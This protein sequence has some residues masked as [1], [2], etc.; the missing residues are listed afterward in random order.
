MDEKDECGGGSDRASSQFLF[1][2]HAIHVSDLQKVSFASLG[3][4]PCAGCRQF[5][6]R[7]R[8]AF[9]PRRDAVS[10]V[11]HGPSDD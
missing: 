8:V 4:S 5:L 10:P 7:A 3:L 1:C 2:T 11:L 9:P 6:G